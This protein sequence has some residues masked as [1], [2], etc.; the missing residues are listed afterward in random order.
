MDKMMNAG[1]VDTA[2]EH[3]IPPRWRPLVHLV[4]FIL[5][6]SLFAIYTAGIPLLFQE[7]S[8]ACDA[9]TCRQMVLVLTTE[10]AR[11][12]AERGLSIEFYAGYQLVQAIYTVLLL[13]PLVGLIFWHKSNSWMG[14]VVSLTLVF[15]GVIF[16][17]VPPVLVFY[18]PTWTLLLDSVRAS[19]P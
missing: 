3:P 13:V 12:L 17:P 18:Y 10:E 16:S 5:T 7:L 4:W 19:R 2:V 11:L 15:F 8:R 9:E 1:T 14:I 6:L